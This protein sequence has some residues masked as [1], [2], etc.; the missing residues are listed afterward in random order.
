MRKVLLPF[1][2]LLAAAALASAA[3]AGVVGDWRVSFSVPRGMESCTI[4][5][6]KQNDGKITGTVVSEDGEFPLKGT[7]S[8]DD[9][10]LVWSVPEQASSSKSPSQ[11]EFAARRSAEPRGSATSAKAR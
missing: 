8:G 6:Q 1:V 4:V 11:P 2:S 9:L 3:D 10:T 5:I 7:I